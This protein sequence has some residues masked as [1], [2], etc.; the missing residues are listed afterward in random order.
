M[1]FGVKNVPAVFARL[2]AGVTQDLQWNSIAVYL[3][4]TTIGGTNFQEHYDLLR[5]VF[6]RL[7]ETGLSQ[8]RSL[9]AATNSACKD[10]GPC[11]TSTVNL[12]APEQIYV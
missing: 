4:D 2:M 6:Q 7:R 11:P 3:D 12:C 8:E 5:D 10:T 1:P 9:Y